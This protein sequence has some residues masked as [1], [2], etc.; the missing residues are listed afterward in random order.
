M[1]LSTQARDPAPHY[2]HSHVGY[3]YRLSNLL[4]A[5]GRGQ[6]EKLEEKMANR[7]RINQFYK[8]TLKDLP[9]IEFMPEASYGRSNCWLT[10]ILI[11]PEKFGADREAI[12]LAL[13]KENIESRPI[14][15]P[16]PMQPVFEI[17]QGA[18]GIA[19]SDSKRHKA[20]VVGGEVSE[21]LFETGLCLP[22][23]TQMTERDLDRVIKV[24][25]DC[26]RAIKCHC[27]ANLKNQ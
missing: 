24:I 6:L 18:R 2:Q 11:T 22:S 25:K 20:R 16:M 27:S 14:W 15:K 5:I 19:Q 3:N 23:G 12:R 7:R 8:K 21:Y 26:C 1:K 13:E 10:V 17:T 4:A 9:G